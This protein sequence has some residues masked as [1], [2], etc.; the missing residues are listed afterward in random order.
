MLHYDRIEG[1]QVKNLILLKVI[2]VNNVLLDTIGFFYNGFEFQDSVCNGYSD[3]TMFCFNISD[4]AITL[5]KGLLIV[6]LFMAL[7]NIKLFI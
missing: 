3:L 6:A 4:T 2:A 7:A 1:I 5:L